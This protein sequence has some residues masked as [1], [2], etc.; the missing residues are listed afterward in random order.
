MSFRSGTIWKHRSP[1]TS[2]SA[3]SHQIAGLRRILADLRTS[4]VGFRQE[5]CC[6]LSCESFKVTAV[7]FCKSAGLIDELRIRALAVF[8]LGFLSRAHSAVSCCFFGAAVGALT[9]RIG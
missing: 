7:K 4:H 5:R 3:Q 6:K 2:L 8:D 1:G 9:V